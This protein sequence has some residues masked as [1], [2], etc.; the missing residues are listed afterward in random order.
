MNI[1]IPTWKRGN[2]TAVLAEDGKEVSSST[3]YVEEGEFKATI[4][5]EQN[6]GLSIEK[7]RRIDFELSQSAGIYVIEDVSLEVE[8]NLGR[9][10]TIYGMDVG[11]NHPEFPTPVT[12]SVA[13]SDNVLEPGSNVVSLPEDEVLGNRRWAELSG[14][15]IAFFHIVGKDYTGDEREKIVGE[16]KQ[17]IKPSSDTRG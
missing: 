10:V 4:P 16:R 3:E 9:P 6:S 13:V 11:F 2:Y 5:A 8:N 15:N 12:S 1:Q 7:A 17:V 14:S